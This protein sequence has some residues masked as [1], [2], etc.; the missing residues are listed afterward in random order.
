MTLDKL[1]RYL[2][3]SFSA[4]LALM[5]I[6]AY[7]DQPA[8][9]NSLPSS[10][11]DTKTAKDALDKLATLYQN[12]NDLGYT[13]TIIVYGPVPENPSAQQQSVT[14]LVNGSVE[15]PNKFSVKGNSNKKLTEFLFCDGTSAYK[16]DPL[17]GYYVKFNPPDSGADLPMLHKPGIQAAMEYATSFAARMFFADQPYDV[18]EA[19]TV[20][21]N[22]VQYNTQDQ[23]IGTQQ[24]TMITE[25]MKE[26]NGSIDTYKVAIDKATGL[27]RQVSESITTNGNTAPVFKEDYDSIRVGS[28]PTDL[29]VFTWQPPAMMVMGYTPPGQQSANQQS[30]NQQS[31]DQQTNNQQSNGQ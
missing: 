17:V 6:P 22:D 3:V 15:K 26:D 25:V 24:V 31:N 20:A 13:S 19:T 29:G 7:S 27:P 4:A 30:A 23:K 12:A 9:D 18:S 28:A 2:L 10:P 16:Y 14:L 5:V 8:P 11:A 21:N 1:G